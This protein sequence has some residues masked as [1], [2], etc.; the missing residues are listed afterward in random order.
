MPPL[1]SLETGWRQRRNAFSGIVTD[2]QLAWEQPMTDIKYISSPAD[3]PAGENYV[4]VAYGYENGNARH[5]RGLTITIAGGKPD[6][7]LAFLAAVELA[8]ATADEEGI[9]TVFACK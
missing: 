6:S 1:P 2:C 4:L 3:I 7:E 9:A 8:K 5:T